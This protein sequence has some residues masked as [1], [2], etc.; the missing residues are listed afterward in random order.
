MVRWLILGYRVRFNLRTVTII[1]IERIMMTH[2][3]S[4]QLQQDLIAYL[5]NCPE[6]LIDILCQAVVDYREAT[7]S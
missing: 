7:H 5:D 6:N 3:E 2:E 1:T 4:E